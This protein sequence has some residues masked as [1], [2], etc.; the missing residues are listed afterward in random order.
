MPNQ[1]LNFKTILNTCITGGAEAM[2]NVDLKLEQI[3][4]IFG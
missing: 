1:C 4:N 3:S 2:I